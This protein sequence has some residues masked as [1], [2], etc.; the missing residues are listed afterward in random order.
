MTYT[1]QC[2]SCQTRFKVNNQQLAA[3]KG[4]VRCGRCA[5]VFNATE[6]FVSSEPPPVAAAPTPAVAAPLPTPPQ[7]AASPLPAASNPADD[8]ELE[9]PDFDPLGPSAEPVPS[10]EFELSLPTEPLAMPTPP[11]ESHDPVAAE[12]EEFQR[13]LAEAMQ[14]RHVSAPIGNPFDEP[15]PTPTATE[16]PE[17]IATRQ[18]TGSE[19]MAEAVAPQPEEIITA[20]EAPLAPV[21]APEPAATVDAASENAVDAPEKAARSGHML[22]IVIA[23]ASVLGLVLLAGQL[24]MLNR[25]RIA[26]EIPEARPTLEA[27]CRTFGCQVGWPTDIALIRTEWSEL[28]QVPEH[29]NLIQL[30]ATAKNHAQYGQSYPMLEV[31]LKDADD[32]VLIRKVFTPKEY[33]KKDDFKL[34]HF[35][36]NS[37]VKITMRLD[38]GKIRPMGYSL[39]WFYP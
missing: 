12:A 14:N 24:V 26:A 35:N 25:T 6:H 23:L 4:L 27:A 34:E 28:A 30:S 36:A 1:T 37:E 18:I 10:T 8:F 21:A 13:A 11:V 31:S 5:H 22:T 17:D 39:Y 7:T 3:A 38:A 33:L 19:P 29:P 20:P 16:L 32:Q 15:L 2:P 9:L